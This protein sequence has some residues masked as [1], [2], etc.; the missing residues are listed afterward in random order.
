MTVWKFLLVLVVAVTL[1]QQSSALAQSHTA[2]LLYPTNGAVN[3][4]LSQPVRWT[5]VA[6][7][8]TY[9]L[10][11]G[12]TR[13]A[14]DLVD[15]GEILQ[16]SY[17]AAQLP[18]GQTVYARLWTKVGGVWR[19]R[20]S[21][22]TVGLFAAMF[23]HPLDGATGVDLTQP[24]HWITLVGAQAYY[25]YVGRSPGAKDVLD[26]GEIAGTSYL[27]IGLPSSGILY[28]RIWTKMNGMWRHSD[29][30]FTS[31]ASI[32][33][34]RIVVPV[35]GAATFDTVQPFEWSEV[36]LARGYRLTIG[37]VFGAD[38]L[39]DTGEIHVT[40]RF[41]PALPIGVPLYGRLQTKISG[42]WYATD[43]AF[44]VGANTVSAAVQIDSALWATDFVRTMA[45]SDNRPFGWTALARQT[46]SQSQYDAF[47]TDYAATLLHVLGEMNIQ[48]AARRLDLSFNATLFNA[49]TLVEL[50]NLDTGDWILLDPTFSLSAKRSDGAW[51][52]AE[53]VSQATR[54][55]DWQAISYVFLS[56]A[57]DAYARGY[58][59]DYPLLYVNVYHQ[60]QPFVA[61]QGPSPLQ[62]L[63]V[64]TL[65]TSGS[66]DVYLVQCIGSASTEVLIDGTHRQVACDGVDATSGS[67]YASSVAAPTGI[68]PSFQLYRLQ[69]FVF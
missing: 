8:Q 37:T 58:Y 10:Y 5:S 44:T 54:A 26:S 15:T 34:S 50:L 46:A 55:F 24:F 62:Y 65:P 27:P 69:R 22:F 38:D 61:G 64:T 19:Y 48:T 53:D 56:A 43:F 12:T 1:G 30:A 7:V 13:G 67:F 66:R 20:D 60:G 21:T 29:I 40:R 35:D 41:V 57:G 2:T 39:H 11:V 45:P 25:L 31:E 59:L 4:D 23:L 49:H 9:Y 33:P 68:Q 18:A 36:T 52:S 16:T 47:C 14:K 63:Q 42:Q 28:A 51:A 32:L 3:A 17:L 6:N